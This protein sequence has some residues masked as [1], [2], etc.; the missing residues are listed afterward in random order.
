MGVFQELVRVVHVAGQL[1]AVQ[2]YQADVS[3]AHLV[4]GD[5]RRG[6]GDDVPGADADIARA[7]DGHAVGEQA[8][9]VADEPRAS[10]PELVR[11]A[12]VHGWILEAC[13]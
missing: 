3:G 4:I 9:A 8:C 10:R 2:G 11:I 12:A 1:G 7:A 6:D 13:L 5:P